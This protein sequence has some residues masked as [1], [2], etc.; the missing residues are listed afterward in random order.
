ML[1]LLALILIGAKL[2]GLLSQ[3][4]GM[5][6]VFGELLLGL[7]LGPSLLNIV[8]PDE[9]LHLLGQIGVIVLMFMAGLETEIDELRNVGA[10]ASLTAIGGVVLPLG[11]GFL[12]GRAFGLEWL[13]ALFLGA[14]LTATS[15]SISAEV[16][17]ELGRLR[18]KIGMTI[19]GAAVIDDVLGVVV[20]SVVLALAGEGVFWLTMLKMV[21]FLPV[22][23]GA[24]LARRRNTQL[25]RGGIPAPAY[26]GAVKMN[27]A[28]PAIDAAL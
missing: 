15:V 26:V 20:L 12:L 6:A 1:P 27:T 18:S 8:A 2:A 23:G 19:L 17:R 10:A 3:R 21:V 14:V 13:H 24:G 9:A 11:G 22:V 25:S 7:V 28:K 5:P 4:F 16:L